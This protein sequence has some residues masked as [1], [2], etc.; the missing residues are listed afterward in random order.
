MNKNIHRVKSIAPRVR[1]SNP[2][3]AQTPTCFLDKLLQPARTTLD[4][5]D[6]K[7]SMAE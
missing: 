1:G 5:T 2:G 6:S 3:D 7:I 4:A